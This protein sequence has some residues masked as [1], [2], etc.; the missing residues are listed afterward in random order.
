MPVAKLGIGSGALL[1]ICC[2]FQFCCC[3]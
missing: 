1:G 3:S 2:F